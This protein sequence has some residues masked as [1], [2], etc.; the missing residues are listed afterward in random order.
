LYKASLENILTEAAPLHIKENAKINYTLGYFQL[1]MLAIK[2]R[3]YWFILKP[4]AQIKADGI[5]LMNGKSPVYRLAYTALLIFMMI[6][7][8][9]LSFDFGITW[10]EKLHN[11]YGYD[12]LKYFQTAGADTTCFTSHPHFPYYGEHFNL[13]TATINTYAPVMGEFETRHFLNAI[14]GFLAMLFASLIARQIGDWRTGF[15]GLVFMF[16]NPNFLGH[17][18][19]NPTDIPFATGCIMATYYIIRLIRNLPNP[20]FRDAFFLAV[21]IGIAIGSRIGGL[22]LVGYSG[23]FLGTAWLL[24]TKKVGIAKGFSI[25]KPYIVYGLI[26]IVLGYIFGLLFWPYG[27]FRPLTNPFIALKNSTASTFFT[28]NH[29]L[30]EGAKI[31]MKNVP[32]YYVP[33]F[34]IINTPLFSVIG[35]VIGILGMFFMS[36]KYQWHFILLLIFTI[37]FP[38][39]YAEYK[40]MYYYNGWRH[41]LFIYP[42]FIIISAIGWD[43][44]I[45]SFNNKVIRIAL[46]VVLVALIGK[47]TYWMIKNH[48]HEYV[49]FNEL[50]GGIDGAYGNYETDYYCNTL[51]PATDWMIENIPE[52]KAGKKLLVSTNNEPLSSQYYFKKVSDSV[53][54]GW[55]RE[56]EKNK[57]NWDYALITTRTMSKTQLMNGCFPPKGTIHV[58]KA[59]NTPLVAIVKRENTFMPDGYKYYL[60][61]Q[62]DTAAYYFSQ[63]IQYAPMEE[64]AYRQLGLCY[65]NLGKYEDAKK[66][67]NKAIELYPENFMAYY[68]L[69]A[70]EMQQNNLDNAIAWFQKS[71]SYKVNYNDS[72]FNMGRAYIGKKMYQ[73]GIDSFQK[74]MDMTGPDPNV[75]SEMG[76]AYLMYGDNNKMMQKDLYQKGANCI[77]N[78]LQMNPNNAGN[79]QNLGVAYMRLGDKAKADACF[80]QA[81]KMGGM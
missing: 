55:L 58:I 19:N 18:M 57:T 62:Y 38:V 54:V 80:Q 65:V 29:E 59:D 78:S 1:W 16:L 43:F 60:K 26:A 24:E 67:F 56:Y 71:V 75:L 11:Q 47:S 41:Y 4:I 53:S 33:K 6:Y 27:Q 10:D 22:V 20:D 73:E 74:I 42:A 63:Y 9:I 45:N 39:A 72:Y 68:G 7:M 8:P 31:Y 77:E 44:L 52:V 17:S 25:I 34:L 81:R 51:R 69:G 70:I 61:G 15:I 49:Y 28:I 30:W 13:Y 37:V 48:P 40:E 79:Y 5:D 21:A 76:V 46:S 32:W 12:M 36:K 66:A 2:M 14:Y 23:L 35:F 3:F 64:E 50:V